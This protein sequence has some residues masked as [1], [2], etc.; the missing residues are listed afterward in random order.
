VCPAPHHRHSR[1]ALR[2]ATAPPHQGRY[3]S[4]VFTLNPLPIRDN[5]AGGRVWTVILELH[6]TS[7]VEL[8][9]PNFG[10]EGKREG[11]RDV[12][13]LAPGM[14]GLCGVNIL[15]FGQYACRRHKAG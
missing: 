3:R 9:S 5:P 10:R 6:R 13:G 14:D 8:D 4:A 7:R 2:F 11:L 12:A 1:L 15:V